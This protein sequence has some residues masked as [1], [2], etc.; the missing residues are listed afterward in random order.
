M[1]GVNIPVGMD[2]PFWAALALNTHIHTHIHTVEGVETKG[3]VQVGVELGIAVR[4][5]G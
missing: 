5:R 4:V 2:G 3:Q 1:G